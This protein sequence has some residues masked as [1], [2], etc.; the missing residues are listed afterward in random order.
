MPDEAGYVSH[1]VTHEVADKL[2]S[3]VERVVLAVTLNEWVRTME[4]D[5]QI[6]A[7]EDRRGEEGRESVVRNHGERR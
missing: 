6:R 7:A 3:D 4:I 1:L 5:E 2:L